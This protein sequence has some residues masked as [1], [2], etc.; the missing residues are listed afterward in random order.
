[1]YDISDKPDQAARQ[2][3]IAQRRARFEGA[4]KKMKEL[5]EAP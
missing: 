5:S 1:M 4:L 3:D 2:A